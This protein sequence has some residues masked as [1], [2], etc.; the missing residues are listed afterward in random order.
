LDSLLDLYGL[1]LVR[2]SSLDSAF[3]SSCF[4]YLFDLAAFYQV[5]PRFSA[6]F[7]SPGFGS[8]FGLQMLDK[9]FDLA[10]V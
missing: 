9:V 3:S 4:G 10:I 1:Q 6:G 5:I 8:V 2:E 7:W